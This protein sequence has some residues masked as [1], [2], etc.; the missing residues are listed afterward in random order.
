M[1][2]PQIIVKTVVS[3][4]DLM[5]AIAVLI[6]DDATDGLKKTFAVVVLLNITGVWI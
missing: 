2:V 5:L 1:N 6:S 4:I 3:T